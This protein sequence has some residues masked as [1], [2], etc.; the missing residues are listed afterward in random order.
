M[1]SFLQNLLIVISL[2]LCVVIAF[3][4]H[5]QARRLK[6]L[7]DKQDTIY[8]QTERIRDL[9]GVVK[10]R[11][12]E[13]QRLESIKATLTDMVKSNR[14][15]I[16]RLREDLD[17]ADTEI[18]RNIKQIADYKGALEQANENIKEQNASIKEQNEQMAKLAEERNEF[19][20]KYNKLAA[21]F[22]DLVNKWN[23]QQ[24]TLATNAP[25][26]K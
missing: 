22:N 12:E 11:N 17:K 20:T 16:T 24:A 14:V 18:A 23:A 19:V 13:I 1:K 26:K 5:N 4:G 21:D 8:Q 9:D 6:E 25:A 2:L 7:Q 3:Q 15:E 10:S